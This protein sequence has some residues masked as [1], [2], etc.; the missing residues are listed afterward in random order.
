MS[1]G[2][3]LDSSLI[4]WCLKKCHTVN[5]HVNIENTTSDAPML[6]TV[7]T[8]GKVLCVQSNTS[9]RGS[10]TTSCNLTLSCHIRKESR[11]TGG[12]RRRGRHGNEHERVNTCQNSTHIQKLPMICGA[13]LELCFEFAINITLSLKTSSCVKR[14]GLN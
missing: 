10:S 5:H 1:E 2:K 14:F 12:R 11:G 7:P 3:E 13:C 8:N 9:S 4:Y 6:H